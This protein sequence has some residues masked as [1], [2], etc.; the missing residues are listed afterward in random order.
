[1]EDWFGKRIPRLRH[2]RLAG[3]GGTVDQGATGVQDPH[4]HANAQRQTDGIRRS[5]WRPCVRHTYLTML[6]REFRQFSVERLLR[7]LVN[8]I[9]QLEKRLSGWEEYFEVV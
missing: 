2:S 1:M 4:N 8:P 3:C 9:R 7:F 5:F 6:R